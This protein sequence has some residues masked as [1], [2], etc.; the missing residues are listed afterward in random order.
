MTPALV[1]SQSAS[2]QLPWGW[3]SFPLPGFG[4]I[5]QR[6]GVGDTGASAAHFR[7]KNNQ[8]LHLE[9]REQDCELIQGCQSLPSSRLLPRLPLQ[10]AAIIRFQRE[11]IPAQ[12]EEGGSP[13]YPSGYTDLS[14]L[15]SQLLALTPHQRLRPSQSCLVSSTKIHWQIQWV[16]PKSSPNPANWTKIPVVNQWGLRCLSLQPEKGAL[17]PSSKGKTDHTFNS[18]TMWRPA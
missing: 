9:S 14:V 3:F 10:V 17:S 13:S 2:H 15:I 18:R 5:V 8:D 4:G 6:N 16:R 12:H 1:C 7:W 11:R